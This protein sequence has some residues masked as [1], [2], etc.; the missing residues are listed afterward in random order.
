M[1]YAVRW[2]RPERA[3]TI[4]LQGRQVVVERDASGKLA[5]FRTRGGHVL[6]L[7]TAPLALILNSGGQEQPLTPENCMHIQ[8]LA[9]DALNPPK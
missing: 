4:E 5:T 6:I 3:S 9:V 2:Y 8:F 1:G 7:K